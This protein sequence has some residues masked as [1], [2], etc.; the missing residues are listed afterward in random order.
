MPAND[1]LPFGTAGGANVLSQV[2]YAALAARSAGF[3]SGIAQ[4]SHLNKAWRQG[5]VAAY[6]LGQFINDLADL[7][8]LD[9]GDTAALLS[10]LKVA[11]RSQSTNYFTAGGT[12][13]ALT[14]TVPSA[15]SSWAKVIGV[16]LNILIATTNTGPA[17]L[18]VSGLAGTIPIVRP[19]GAAL[20]A[21]D[22]R[23]GG[24]LRGMYNGYS[25]E[26][27][28]LQRA[29]S[30]ARAVFT[31]VGSTAWVVPAGVY[32]V[33]AEAWG[34]GGGGGFNLSGGN[35]S[36][37]SGATAGGYARRRF[38]VTPGQTIT[39]VVG[40]GGLGGYSLPAPG[41]PGGATTITIGGVTMTAPGGY[42]GLNATTVGQV[43][44]S[45][46]R[47]LDPTNADWGRP[48]EAGHFGQA[49]SPTG[50]GGS[51]GASPFGGMTARG[52]QG[53]PSPGSVPGGGGAATS[54]PS[55]AGGTGARGEAVI[56][57]DQP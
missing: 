29:P 18:A 19:N 2:S 54:D 6:L 46:A 17:S 36:A 31:I 40:A 16:P 43:A 30:R 24:I 48:G 57:Y 13:N 20:S 11:Y 51:G 45:P 22:L 25:L 53:A 5:S 39:V 35:S 47:G 37:P 32:E 33:D 34:A 14:I 8:A 7:D 38:A 44:N 52:G 41:Q 3:S 21:G 42:G 49:V 23:A 12:A 56:T 50:W 55:Y 1:F 4:S 9:N 15:F 10:A 26:M 27:A 28:G